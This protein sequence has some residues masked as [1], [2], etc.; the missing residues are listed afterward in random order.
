MD[1]GGL[2]GSLAILYGIMEYGRQEDQFVPNP[3]PNRDIPKGAKE[4][5]H[6][7]P[8]KNYL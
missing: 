2:V 8:R 4:K 3:I 6:F 7:Y 1:C 5:K